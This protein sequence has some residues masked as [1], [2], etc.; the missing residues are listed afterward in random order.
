MVLP[1]GGGPTGKSP[2]FVAK[3]DLV[4]VNFGAL[5]RDPYIWGADANEF[6]PERWLGIKPSNATYM[7]FSAG[8]RICP[9]KQMTLT[10]NAYVLVQLLRR[11][12]RLE[13]RD[14]VVEFIEESRLT[15][16]SRNGVRVGLIPARDS[17]P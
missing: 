5:Q 16:E 12:E 17:W 1:T 3:G 2:V 9:G 8:P 7:P 10:E 6:R 4:T 14:E 13:N 11:F 15:V